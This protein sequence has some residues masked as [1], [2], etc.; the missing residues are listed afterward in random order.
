MTRIFLSGQAAAD[1]IKSLAGEAEAPTELELLSDEN[2]ALREALNR[3]TA[4]G[5]SAMRGAPKELARLEALSKS[6]LATI[7]SLRQSFAAG[8]RQY[9]EEAKTLHAKLAQA[10][11]QRDA[12][13]REVESVK[14]HLTDSG[15]E[16]LQA[17]VAELERAK[18]G[19]ES[20]VETLAKQL[21]EV[22]SKAQEDY[23][24]LLATLASRHHLNVQL[25]E[26][27]AQLARLKPLLAR[28][29]DLREAEKAYAE[30]RLDE[31]HSSV[32]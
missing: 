6:R 16:G 24:K 31:L 8:E 27:K 9:Q 14:Q 26:A 32:R 1:F 29:V 22:R 10:E 2:A 21:H 13:L 18:L 19:Q 11:A 20:L 3:A 4:D 7:E 28:Q 15:V 5:Q 12:A 17:R 25:E 30:A 23:G